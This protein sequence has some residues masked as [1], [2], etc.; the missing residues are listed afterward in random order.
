MM[1]PLCVYTVIFK[2]AKLA[3]EWNVLLG[4]H[5]FKNWIYILSTIRVALDT[6]AIHNQKRQL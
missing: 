2:K 4:I 6:F 1:L 3:C 5:I